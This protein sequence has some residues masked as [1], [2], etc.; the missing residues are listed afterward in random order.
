MPTFDTPEPIT[1]TIEL[2][3]GDLRITAGDRRDTIVE[4]RP[5]DPGTDLDVRAADQTRVE[6]GGGRLLVKAPKQRGL[7][8]FGKAGSVDVEIELPAGS[9]LHT[10]T[11]VA[12]VTGTGP[13]GECWIKTG[14][15]DIRLDRTGPVDLK[16]GGG[17]IAVL[18]VAGNALITTGTGELRVGAVDGDALLR[19]S[20]GDTWVGPVTGDL[21]VKASNGDIRVGRA[22]AGVTA[23]SSAGAIRVDEAAGGTVSLKTSMGELEVGIPS[24]TAAHLDL[25]T[26]FGNVLNRLAASDAPPAGDQAVEVRARTSYG[27]IVIRRPGRESS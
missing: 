8:L 1:A 22:A 5:S 9:R 17:S 25:H 27:D 24:G 21:R 18:E 4:V 7:G 14:V 15:G 26:Q 3:V 16:T 10:E 23:T 13:L 6:Y 19:N 2:V 12:A 20:D 11:G